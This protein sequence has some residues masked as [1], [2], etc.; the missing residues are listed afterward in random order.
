DLTTDERGLPRKAG[1]RVDIGAYEFQGVVLTVT[2]STLPGGT[3]GT[4]YSQ[5]LDATGGTPPY[6]FS[7]VEGALPDG[8]TLSG[9]S[10]TGDPTNG[11]SF[12]FTIMASDSNHDVGC[13]QSYT[14]VIAGASVTQMVTNTNDSGSGSLRQAIANAQSGDKVAFDPNL[15]GQTIT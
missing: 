15:N 1:T 9:N 8:L 7:V 2:P 10:I 6:T 4:N 12:T 5:S 13:H 11:G 14:V 3:R